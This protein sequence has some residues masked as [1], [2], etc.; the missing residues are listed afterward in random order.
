MIRISRVIICSVL[1]LFVI[2]ILFT[3]Y[4]ILPC[5]ALS[6][7]AFK[8]FNESL[9]HSMYSHI[10]NVAISLTLSYIT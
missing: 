5:Y 2:Q 10:T 1:K 3:L 4:I 8:S 9:I 6:I 7:K